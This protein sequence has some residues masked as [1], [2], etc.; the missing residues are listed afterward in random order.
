MLHTLH[1]ENFKSL[2]SVSLRLQQVNLLIGPNN[3]G[4]TNLLKALELWG[5]IM[6]KNTSS[7][8]QALRNLLPQVYFKR[9]HELLIEPKIYFAASANIPKEHSQ[10]SAKYVVVELELPV[11]PDNKE[12]YSLFYFQSDSLSSLGTMILHGPRVIEIFQQFSEY[13]FL[14]LAPYQNP[15]PEGFTDI[16]SSGS[17]GLMLSDKSGAKT[18]SRL[19]PRL[20]DS[21]ILGKI[22]PFALPF[23]QY[24]EGAFIY[25]PDPRKMMSI[26]P[27]YAGN[28]RLLADAS[29]IVAFLDTM[30]GKYPEV[31]R[32]MEQDLERCVGDFIG[33]RLNP[34]DVPQND[35]LRKLHG[36]KTFKRLGLKDRRDVIYWA[37]ELSEGTLYFL[38]IL[39]IVHQPNPPKLLMLEEP[40][41]AIH[42]RRIREVLDLIFALA[43]EKD[44]QVIMTTH[45]PLVVDAFAEMP[46]AI[47]VVDIDNGETSIRNLQT[48]IIAPAHAECDAKGLPRINYTE[49]LGEHW[50]VGFL[51]GVPR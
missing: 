2:K 32:A 28:E 17:H 3:S 40:E 7:S 10:T 25:K 20:F 49:S 41:T 50:S 6:E 35:D 46:E 22:M 38:A 16:S 24:L 45:S 5:K 15:V 26:A 43:D 33:I 30:L 23:Y 1:I 44:I 42:P 9:N 29:N 19:I 48:D 13:V 39:A 8:A 27:L 21:D 11:Q 51:G 14:S 12:E 36:D 31:I 18:F 47:H 34:E 4:K 37:D